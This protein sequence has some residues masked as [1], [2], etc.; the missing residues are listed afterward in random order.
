MKTLDISDD[1]VFI[2]WD[3]CVGA[4]LQHGRKLS[5][6]KHTDP[7]KTY[8]W[9]YAKALAA[10]LEEWDLDEE[11]SRR[12]ISVAV[13]HAK[14]CGK[15]NKGLA[16]LH[17]GNMLQIC[18]DDL[19]KCEDNNNQSNSSLE[20][21]KRWFDSQVG[22]KDPVKLLLK[23]RDPDAFCNLVI[24]YQ[25]SKLSPLFLSLSRSCGKAMAKLAK[26]DQHERGLLPKSTELYRIRSQFLE[27]L[28]NKKQ[29]HNILQDDWRELCL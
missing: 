21:I 10:K 1:Q 6:P 16:A 7:R 27:D 18:L 13:K 25:A 19:K 9:R 15:L 11:T 14:E 23:R 17:Q 4:Y 20:H 28:N 29:A 22:D 26:Q 8:Q 3:W 24:W 12:F 5:F 2:V